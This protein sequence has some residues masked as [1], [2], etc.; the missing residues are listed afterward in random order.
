MGISF[1][2]A[3]VDLDRARKSE[4]ICHC[5]AVAICP[6]SRVARQ[7]STMCSCTSA[8]RSHRSFLLQR[9]AQE[10]L[11]HARQFAENTIRFFGILRIEQRQRNP[12]PC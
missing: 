3:G 9:P 4:T 11:R 1:C 5:G 6:L 7:Q 10:L 8:G 2:A 12:R